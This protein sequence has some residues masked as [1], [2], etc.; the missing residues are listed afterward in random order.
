VT[1]SMLEIYN[2][3]I[4]DLFQDPK[5]RTKEGLKIREQKDNGIFVEGLSTFQV[6]SYD[7]IAQ[8][9]EFGTAMRTIGATN[10]NASSSRAH[11]VTTIILT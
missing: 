5:M 2:E 1:V 3:H 8:Y 6:A 7:E 9:I 4:F 10:M 11:T